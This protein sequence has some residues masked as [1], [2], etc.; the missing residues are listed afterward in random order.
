LESSPSEPWRFVTRLVA[1]GPEVAAN[2][3]RQWHGHSRQQHE[4]RLFVSHQD[5]LNTSSSFCPVQLIINRQNRATGIT[6]ICSTPWRLRL[7]S[8]AKAPVARFVAARGDKHF[9]GVELESRIDFA[10]ALG[11]PHTMTKL[12]VRCFVLKIHLI[13]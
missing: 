7:S 1:P 10:I 2:T 3:H 6:K 4:L 5:M 8:R 13:L 11:K 12:I 9:V